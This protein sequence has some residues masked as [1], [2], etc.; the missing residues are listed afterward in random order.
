LKVGALLVNPYSIEQIS[1]TLYR[2]LTMTPR[3]RRRR[4]LRMRHVVKKND[5]NNWL[6]KCWS[7]QTGNHAENPSIHKEKP[8]EN[9]VGS[10]L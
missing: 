3:E 4:M 5:I 1:D 2:A 7:N 6:M 10:G 8:F 9:P